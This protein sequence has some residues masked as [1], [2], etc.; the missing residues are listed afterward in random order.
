MSLGHPQEGVVKFQ[1]HWELADAAAYNRELLSV[2]DRLWGMGLI[3]FDLEQNVGFGNLSQRM[4]GG[5][6]F[7]ISGTQTGH[8]IPSR[9]DQFTEVIR[10][11][12]PANEVWC[13]G[14][15]NA[16]SETLTHAALYECSE[17]VQA[18]I[19][20]HALMPWEKLKLTHVCT[21]QG[22]EYGTPEMAAAM[23]KGWTEPR[24]Q[25]TKTL[26]MDGHEGGII[27]FGI[28][29]AEAMEALLAALTL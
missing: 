9:M 29:F 28:T 23:K 12:L 25:Q 13:R 21:P 2:R 7:L 8:L 16:S 26:V 17:T 1:S 27:S 18:V 6:S 5:S 3:G 24:L 22:V 14:P 15:V 4:P 11:S 10:W 19:H 20:I